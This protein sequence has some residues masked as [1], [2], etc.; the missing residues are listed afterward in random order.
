MDL[1]QTGHIPDRIRT[2]AFRET[3]NVKRETPSDVTR[4]GIPAPTDRR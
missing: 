1:V 4:I 2:G 3:R